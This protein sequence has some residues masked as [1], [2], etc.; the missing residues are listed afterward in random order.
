MDK[1]TTLGT[2]E[3]QLLEGW[4]DTYK[5]SQLTLWILLALKEAPKHMATIKQFMAA[6]TGGIADA[7]DKSIYRAL[8][9]LHEADI[10]EFRQVPGNGGPD[11]KEYTITATGRQLLQAFLKRNIIDTLYRQPIRKLIEKE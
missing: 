3:T 10:V 6:A 9:R 2:Y 4:E 11:R 8:R 1:A 5:K 7:D